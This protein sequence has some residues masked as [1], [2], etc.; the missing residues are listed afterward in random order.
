MIA[1]NAHATSPQGIQVARFR[2]ASWQSE[3]IWFEPG[4]PLDH[5]DYLP[6]CPQDDVLEIRVVFPQCWNGEN[7]SAPDNRSHM[8]YP[9]EAVPPRTGTGA[10]PASHPVAIPE[11]SYNFAIHVTADTGPPSGWRF[12][13]DR[14]EVSRPG[15]S[16]HGLDER[17]G[18]GDHGDHRRELPSTRSGM[19][20][21]FA[22]RW[23][24]LEASRAK[25]AVPSRIV[26]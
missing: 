2:C 19:R 23:N 17:L 1:G 14:P 15:V 12:S 20:S 5:V 3:R 25:L 10:C 16:L 24:P 18:P 21:W 22:G 26:T 8:A 4:D 9:R 7:L 6:D 13:S 11:I